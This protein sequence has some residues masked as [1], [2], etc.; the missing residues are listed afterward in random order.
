MAKYHGCPIPDSDMDG[1][2]DEVD[3]CPNQ[4]GPADNQGCP[5]VKA[6]INSRA[7]LLAT[8]VM[9]QLNSTRLTNSSYPAIREL[10]DSLKTNPD[11]NLL[12]E[13]H[14][15]NT[16]K[17]GYNMKLSLERAESVKMALLNL[18]IS[19]DRIRVKGY[20]DTQP[21]SDNNTAKGKAKNRRVV[22]VFELKNR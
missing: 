1:V 20:G 7:Q 2:N 13:G 18:S 6:T 15:D 5:V 21:V 16:G 12:I 11:L 17:P 10:A 4:P 3:R 22:C 19:P 8:Q 14:T 9:F